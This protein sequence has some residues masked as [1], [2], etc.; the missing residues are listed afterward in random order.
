MATWRWCVRGGPW[1]GKKPIDEETE[2]DNE[3]EAML[4]TESKPP[5]RQCE[6]PPYQTG[7]TLSSHVKGLATPKIDQTPEL[8]TPRLSTPRLSFSA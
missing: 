6:P 5:S 7:N 3:K 8:S 1:T 4:I 2:L